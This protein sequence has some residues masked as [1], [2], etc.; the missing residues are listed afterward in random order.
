MKKLTLIA[1]CILMLVAPTFAKLKVVASSSDLGSIVREVGGENVDVASIGQGKSNLHFVEMLPSYMLKVSQANI[2][3]K[4]GLALDQWAA[5]IIDGARNDKLVVIDCSNGVD[6]LEKPTGKVDASMGDVHPDG[7][8]HYWL[9]PRNGKVIAQNILTGLSQADPANAAVYKANCENFNRRLDSA[10]QVWSA[11][12]TAFKRLPIISYHSSWAYLAHAFDLDVVGF[13]EPKPG[14]EPTASH[15]AE[16]IDIIKKRNVKV[17]LREPYFSDRAPNALAKATGATVYL[18]PSS[19]GG[20]E[21]ARDY[22][23]LFDE[24]ISVLSKGV[25]QS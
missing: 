2:Y 6:V 3:F 9:D 22:F 11:K 25:G 12:A 20:T 4:V 19:V 17:I 7:N 16:L 14:I 1:A 8:P 5:G 23:S 18:V 13:I 15:T 24:L 10:W 21:G